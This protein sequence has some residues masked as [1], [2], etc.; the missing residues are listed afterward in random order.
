LNPVQV[1]HVRE[2]LFRTYRGLVDVSDL[3][4]KPEPD[5]DQAF[6]SRALAAL[7]V[8]HETGYSADQAALTVIDGYDDQGIDAVAV[9]G[10]GKAPRLWLVQA[11]WHQK[12]NASLKQD[13]ALKF[14]RG[15]DKILNAEYHLFNAKFQALREH[16]DAV[17]G[18]SKVQV[19]LVVALLGDT[20]L[21]RNAQAVIDDE[22]EKLNFAR[23][24]VDVR[25]LGLKHFHRAILG[26]TAEP[27]ID[28]DARVEGW[29]YQR[30]PYEAY[31]GTM[32]VVE[33]AKWY[34]EYGRALFAKNI[35]DSLDITEVNSGIIETL[36]SSPE[37][38]WY[39][40]N[41]ITVLCDSVGKTP[42][43][44]SAPGGLGEFELIGASVVNGAQTVAAIHRALKQHPHEANPG[45]VLVRFISLEKCP[46]G[47]G[48]EVTQKTNT[49][50][51][52]ETRDF[53]ALDQDQIRLR[54]DFAVSLG[55]IYTIKRGEGKPDPD[56]GCSIVEAAV[57]LACAHRNAEF[58]ARAKRDEG[59][60]WE[61]QTYNAIFG[62]HPN[63]YR[64]WRSVLL[65]RKVRDSLERISEDLQGRASAVASYGDLL[66]AH[67]V[68]QNVDTS[69]I[70][71]PTTDW[72][73]VIESVPDLTA[74]AL[75]WLID[76]IDE[77]YGPTSHVIA[78]CR[79]SERS[80]MVA[81]RAVARMVG[82]ETATLPIAYRSASADGGRRANAVSVLVDTGY[83]PDGTALEFRA[84]TRPEQRI[85]S[86]WLSADPQR[87]RAS[88]VNNRTSPLLWAADG[89]GYSP[90]GLVT[91]MIEQATGKRP[92]AI[93]GPTRWFW[94]GK[95]SLAELAELARKEEEDV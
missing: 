77:E 60:L 61:R 72:D 54:E 7:A 17:L 21:D 67:V 44:A 37:H 66:T 16:V 6:L 74:I 19:T 1:R 71:A 24:F 80:Q 65:L 79:S 5:R 45:R 40:N 70:D 50:N 34:D 76:S 86:S 13:D 52:V 58:T 73:P 39:F 83:I 69:Q 38:F 93:Q 47:F 89:K 59:L 51:Q 2:A 56:K 78:A 33:I 11:K 15:L 41:G 91:V 48:T 53:A 9:S 62:R 92:R 29:N 12:G 95:G 64:V 36:V 4:R 23:P 26:D 3:E 82:N 81:S 32:S 30:E 22:C 31:Y 57:A 85:L 25:I 27:Q 8:Q 42:K 55:K 87:G 63:A 35:R 90:S 46:E 28:L 20:R 84:A 49:Q 88:W 75:G 94:P 18:N 14:T 43:F 68:F 10:P